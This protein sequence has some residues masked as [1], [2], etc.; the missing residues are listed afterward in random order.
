MVGKGQADSS[1]Q[2]GLDNNSGYLFPFALYTYGRVEVQFQW[3]LRRPPFEALGLRQQLQARL[4]AIPG[5]DIRDEALSR[6]PA[7]SL[8]NAR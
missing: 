8:A 2:A 1:F 7:I 6:R 3:M 5:V 4:D